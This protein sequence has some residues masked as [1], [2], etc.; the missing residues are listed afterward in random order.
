MPADVTVSSDEDGGHVRL[1]VGDLL[2]VRLPENPTTGYRWQFTPPAQLAPEGDSFNPVAGGAVGA[3]GERLARFRAATLGQGR[4]QASHKRPWDP[5]SAAI[6][7][8]A[9]DVMVDQ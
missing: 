3:G 4:L 5:P 7:A 2:I 1:H 8:F 9:I 6:G